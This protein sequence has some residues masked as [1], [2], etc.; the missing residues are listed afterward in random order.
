MPQVWRPTLRGGGVLRLRAAPPSPSPSRH[1]LRMT[2]DN[3]RQP[4]KQGFQRRM[5]RS[6]IACRRQ[7]RRAL[8]SAEGGRAAEKRRNL[9]T[10]VP[11]RLPVSAVDPSW[12]FIVLASSHV[13]SRSGTGLIGRLDGPSGCSRAC[14]WRGE[15]AERDEGGRSGFF[16]QGILV[17]VYGVRICL[18]AHF[19]IHWTRAPLP[20]DGPVSPCCTRK[21]AGGEPVWMEASGSVRML[22]EPFRRLPA[23]HSPGGVDS[24]LSPV[25]YRLCGPLPA[26]TS[27]SVT[28][29][30]RHVNP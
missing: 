9:F 8:A 30:S 17:S 11:P 26:V 5:E 13:R 4:D 7:P 16:A 20:R 3:V 15:D 28:R 19:A 29:C 22:R 12:P 10:R 6:A 1:F 24:F 14:G 18:S 2:S 23:N 21:R 27:S 25:T